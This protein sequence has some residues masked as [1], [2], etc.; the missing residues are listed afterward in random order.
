MIDALQKHLSGTSINYRVE[1]YPGTGH[2]FVF[3]K[4]KVNMKKPQQ[5]NIGKDC[6][7]FL[8]EKP[9]VKFLLKSL[10]NIYEQ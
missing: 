6:S 7:V 10:S 1:L 9:Q 4:E 3:P 5:S 2:G 8:R